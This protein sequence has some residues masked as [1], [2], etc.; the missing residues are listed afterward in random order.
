L[1]GA[2]L[3]YLRYWVSGIEV[4]RPS[5]VELLFTGSFDNYKD[6]ETSD[7]GWPGY[8]EARLQAGCDSKNVSVVVSGEAQTL[9][10]PFQSQY[11]GRRY[12]DAFDAMV[13]S[14]TGVRELILCGDNQI[15]G[16]GQS[17]SLNSVDGYQGLSLT[18]RTIKM[19]KRIIDQAASQGISTIVCTL[20]PSGRTDKETESARQA[21]NAW[22][23]SSGA[24]AGV[25]DFD[26]I[27][28]NAAMPDQLNLE[29]GTPGGNFSLPTLNERAH[30]ALA[31]SIDLSLFTR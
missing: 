11:I 12:P 8:L 28:R 22:M 17:S 15:M 29:F 7:R 4:L 24:F 31:D 1:T 21:V 19:F 18:D 3:N 14:Q 6:R 30:K 27:T 16:L 5:N 2:K 9:L 20:P 10:R 13:T 25:L 26:A 23:R